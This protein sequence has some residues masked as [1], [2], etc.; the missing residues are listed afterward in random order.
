MRGGLDSAS[1][2]SLRT[3]ACMLSGD[4]RDPAAGERVRRAVDLQLRR[5][6][7][8]AQDSDDVR[9]EVVLAL[10]CA[11]AGELPLPLELVCARASAIA[12]HKAIDHGR[13][14]ARA[15]LAFGHALP[16]PAADGPWPGS[17]A[18]GLDEVTAA[19]HRRRVHADL[20]LALGRLDAPQRAAIA[21]HADGGA[22]RAAGLPRSTYYRVLAHAQARLRS[23]L[24]GR[25]AGVGALGGLVQRAREVL[26]HVEAVHGAAAAATAAVAVT[27]VVALGVHDESA[28]H[29]P[30]PV[31]A[32]AVVSSGGRV[33]AA[34]V[35]VAQGAPAAAAPRER[36]IAPGLSPATAPPRAAAAASTPARLP[37]PYDPSTYDC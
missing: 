4:P 16:E 15:P 14:R 10:L 29:L 33:A 7:V 35:T 5:A 1:H 3:A 8:E 20:V 22:A 37:C 2:L 18:D 23:D 11:P 28:H 12:R 24:R 17:L 31:P 36:V 32:V 34:P 9:T 25:L 30:L 6:G 19:A 27:A 26:Q 13:R 21:A